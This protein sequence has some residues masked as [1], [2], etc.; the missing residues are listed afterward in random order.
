VK[1]T[2]APG[3]AG[4]V[5]NIDKP[6]RWTSHDAVQRIRRILRV[7]KVGHTGTLDPFAT[8]V[9]LC[10]V[11][12]ATK[13]SNYLMDLPKEYAGTMLY[14]VRTSTGDIAGEVLERR[15]PPLPPAAA[16]ADAARAF[17]G[18]SLQVPPMVSALKHEGQRLY[19]LARRGI[20]VEREPRKIFVESFEILGAE[21]QRIRFR[22]RCARGT[23][24]RTLVEDF[25]RHLGSVACVEEL[26]RTRVGAFTVE[27]ALTLEE[28][29]AA[30]ALRSAAIPMAD[31]LVNLP[32]W[33][34]PGFWVRKLREGHA[35][36]WPVVA[37]EAPPRAGEVGRLL[38][39][40]GELVGL[41][42]AVETPGP[43]ERDWGEALTLELLRVI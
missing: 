42:R 6:Q 40:T 20:T 11:G 31:A 25:G 3:A 19:A 15:T 8:G 13:L 16:L 38:G 24:V 4:F 41:G 26:C 2:P 33:R 34:I 21:A 5:L 28:T 12:R 43:A 37:L 39:A 23:Y 35:P 17:E 27:T 9:L 1:P 18:E 30:E 29:T 22:V 7:R 32:A 10:C 14:G 36:P